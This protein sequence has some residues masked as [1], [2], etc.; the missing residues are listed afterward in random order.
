MSIDNQYLLLAV[1]QGLVGLGF[2]LAILVSCAGR[3]LYLVARP[4]RPEDQSLVFAHMAVLIGLSVTL[5]TVYMGE[6]VVM[7]FFLFI[8][9]VQGMRPAAAETAAIGL[10][11][12]RFEFRRVLT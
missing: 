12:A 1:T 4:A 3:L 2:F 6:Q 5:T 9:W 8:G 7:L 11:P 10:V